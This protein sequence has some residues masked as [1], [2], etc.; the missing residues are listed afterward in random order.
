MGT[1]S[2]G[3]MPLGVT[4]GVTGGVSPPT[5]VTIYPLSLAAG[6]SS[7][8]DMQSQTYPGFG[9]IPFGPGVADIVTGFGNT[10]IGYNDQG[11]PLY[12]VP[13]GTPGTTATFVASLINNPAAV[14]RTIIEVDTADYLTNW[15]LGYGGGG[16][17]DV[18]TFGGY[19][20]GGV[21]ALTWSWKLNIIF[22][23][24]SNGTIATVAGTPSTTQD[25]TYVANP[26]FGIGEYLLLQPARGGYV[27]PGDQLILNVVATAT[28]GGGSTTATFQ[29]E[30]YFV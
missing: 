18:L 9:G 17:S 10:G 29:C 6:F 27:N 19:A 28:N 23:S 4:E 2:L 22:S 21:G 11:S 30:I 25:A 13:P 15:N 26:G 7:M 5:A 14:G 3:P 16:Y 8:C 1:Y 20:D 12:M 24:L